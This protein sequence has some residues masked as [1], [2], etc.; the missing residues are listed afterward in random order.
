MCAS[1]LHMH[2]ALDSAGCSTL[3]HALVGGGR[4]CVSKISESAV[5]C[6]SVEFCCSCAASGIASS[7]SGRQSSADLTLSATEWCAVCTPPTV[8]VAHRRLSACA[9]M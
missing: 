8:L 5:V 9:E 3:L 2:L 7:S 4:D 1:M 6:V